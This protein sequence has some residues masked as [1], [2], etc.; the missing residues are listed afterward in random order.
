MSQSAVGRELGITF[1]QLQKNES[2]INRI[3]AS[4]LYMLSKTLDV[5]IAY[6][7][8]DLPDNVRK[9]MDDT[10]TLDESGPSGLSDQEIL[11]LVRT[12]Y[13]IRD[14]KLRSRL[15][16]LCKTLGRDAN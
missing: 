6:F 16:E 3:G 13:R 1:Q 2:G 7:F 8:E 11:K 14:P 12:Y 10:V 9:R 4:R 5:P 15:L